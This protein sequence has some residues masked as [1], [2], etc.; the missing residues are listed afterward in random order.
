ML[1]AISDEAPEIS[2]SPL[3]GRD[4][5]PE[6]LAQ[7]S[8]GQLAQTISP[9]SKTRR[10]RTIPNFG[11]S[12]L[13]TLLAGFF[14]FVVE[15]V[16]FSA[17]LSFHLLPHQ[18]TAQLAREPKLIVPSMALAYVLTLLAAALVFRLLWDRSFASGIRWNREAVM[19]LGWRLPALGLA[20]GVTVQLLQNYLPMPKT[21][22][23]DD[24]FRTRADV[25]MVTAFGTLLA[26]AFEEIAFRGMLLPAIGNAWDWIGNLSNPGRRE[27]SY[28]HPMSE[29]RTEISR[30]SEACS[31]TTPA[32][33]FSSALTS[34]IFALL[35]AEQLGHSVSPLILLFSVSVV[36]TLVRIRTVSVAASTLVHASYN[37]S[38]FLTMFI[39][40][41]GYQH[42]ERLK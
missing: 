18:T 14:I 42:L 13:F 34:A 19:R 30:A 4:P 12:V 31:P 38:V 1:R 27:N 6:T 21:V 24:Y 2:G 37:F 28:I 17:T 22:P 39:G 32:L 40:T 10:T 35:H 33:L 20:V 25:W 7:D 23:M 8:F 41:G 26:P 5:L 9:L 29:A 36:L 15:A 11:D 3:P 16:F